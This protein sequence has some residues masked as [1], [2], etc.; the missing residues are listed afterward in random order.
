MK[1]KILIAYTLSITSYKLF[2]GKLNWRLNSN[3]ARVWS[4]ISHD[5]TTNLLAFVKSNFINFTY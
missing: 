4:D 1:I 3:G 2:S 5:E